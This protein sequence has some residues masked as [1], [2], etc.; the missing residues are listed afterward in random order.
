MA[1]NVVC[2]RC[3]F[4]YK[5]NELR[6]EWTGLR[7][8]GTCWDKRNPQD[9]LKA[10]MDKQLPPWTQPEPEPVFTDG[11]NDWDAL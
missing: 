3:G 4:Q 9:K 11:V 1:W 10:K 5:N 8:C 2:A 7:V 6:R